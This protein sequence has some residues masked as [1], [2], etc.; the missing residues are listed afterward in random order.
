MTA[1]TIGVPAGNGAAARLFLPSRLHGDTPLLVSVHGISRNADEHLETFSAAADYAGV[2]VLV[3]YFS[4]Q[5]F[6][7]YQRIGREGHGQRA[8]VALMSLL[9]EIKRRHGLHA[10]GTYLFGHS[11]GA[12]F[13]HRLMMTRPRI[14]MG[15]VVSAAGW[16]TFP[17]PTLP[18]PLGIAPGTAPSG[19]HFDLHAFLRVPGCVLVGEADVRRSHALRT[20][21]AV[22]TMQG[23]NR[24]ERAA[25]WVDAMNRAAAEHGLAAPISF[26]S[27]PGAGHR[28]TGVMRRGGTRR[29]FQ[30]LFG[31][32]VPA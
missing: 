27:I 30:E 19:L 2:A 13:V 23:T 22:D 32:R 29:V 8:D 21:P 6:P 26:E 18:F 31:I 25:R 9:H 4:R 3:P 7:D 17:D 10:G 24:R 28:F 16:Y 1:A 20:A 12:Q 15:Y 14:A 5:D 11:G